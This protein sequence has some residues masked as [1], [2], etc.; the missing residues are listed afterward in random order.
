[1]FLGRN[2]LANIFFGSLTLVEVP[3]T[4]DI[5]YGHFVVQADVFIFYDGTCITLHV[6]V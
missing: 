4:M 5:V 6:H 1:M 3:A 2:I